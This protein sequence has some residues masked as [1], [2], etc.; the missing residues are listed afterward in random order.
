MI[1]RC[2]AQHSHINGRHGTVGD[3]AADSAGESE[4]RV[5]INARQLLGRKTCFGILLQRVQLG[6]A[7]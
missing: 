4:T 7:S 3:G 1:V 6:A 5:Q 2:D